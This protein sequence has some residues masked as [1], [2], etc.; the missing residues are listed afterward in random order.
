[1]SSSP[2]PGKASFPLT[3][4]ASHKSYFPLQNS[5]MKYLGPVLQSI[6]C[7]TSSLKD[8][9]VKCFTSLYLNTLIFFVVKNERSFAH[10]FNKKI[11]I[12]EKL[13]SEN[14]TKR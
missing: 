8:Q 5:R 12:F 1:M 6:V 2:H 4:T 9:L 10:F 3:Q 7:L 13:T 11:G 14:L